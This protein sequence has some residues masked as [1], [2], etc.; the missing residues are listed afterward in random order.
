MAYWVYGRDRTTGQPTEPFFSEAQTEE[1][2]RAEAAAQDMIVESVERHVGGPEGAR[3]EPVAWS[4]VAEPAGLPSATEPAPGPVNAPDA[5]EFTPDQNQVIGK[6]S[7]YMRIFGAVLILGGA[8]RLIGGLTAGQAEGGSWLIDG[9]L[10]LIL[11]GLTIS[12]A[13]AFTAIVD[14]RGQD[15]HHLMEALGRLKTIYAIQVWLIGIALVLV[16][17]LLMGRR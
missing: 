3:V 2:A 16:A 9:T 11:G 7:W 10:G 5:Y 1:T 14:T 15:L 17:I 6:L 13:R 4:P 12:A 8:L